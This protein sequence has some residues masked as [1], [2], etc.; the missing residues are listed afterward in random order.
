MAVTPNAASA[1]TRA[2]AE[3]GKLRLVHQAGQQQQLQIEE[4]LG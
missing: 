4:E 1:N 2:N 3:H